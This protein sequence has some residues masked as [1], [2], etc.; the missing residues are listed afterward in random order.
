MC[1]NYTPTRNQTWLREQFDTELP[2]ALAEPAEVFP[3]SWTPLLLRERDGRVRCVTARFG[4]IPPWAKDRSIGR[5]TYNARSETVA[6]KPSF[7]SAWQAGQLGLVPMDAFFEP[8]WAEGHAERWR[9]TA[10]DG[11][12]LAVACLWEAWRDPDTGEHELS[13]SLLTV[14]ADQHPLLRRF[15]RPD[16]EKRSV[17]PLPPQAFAAWWEGPTEARQALL[18]LPEAPTLRAEAAPRTGTQRARS[19]PPSTPTA[20]PTQGSLF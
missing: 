5:R 18:V 8:N 6:V 17:V 10:A 13:C 9:I 16:E 19:A 4:L 1:V 3:G 15:H 2:P 11:Q 20:T 14:N 7:R 12:P